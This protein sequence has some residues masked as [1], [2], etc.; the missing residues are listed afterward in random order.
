MITGDLPRVGRQTD[1]Q[2][3]GEDADVRVKIISRLAR[4]H[5]LRQDE[6]PMRVTQIAGRLLNRGCGLR[7]LRKRLTTVAIC[8]RKR[9]SRRA[10]FR[11]PR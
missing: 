10:P 3:L 1:L 2:L 5:F 8:V 4:E 11:F 9:A 7:L 6:E